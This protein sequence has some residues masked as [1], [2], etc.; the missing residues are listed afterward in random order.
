[1]LKFIALKDTNNGMVYQWRAV[2]PG[3]DE[4]VKDVPK[5]LWK[6]EKDWTEEEI[7]GF[8]GLDEVSDPVEEIEQEAEEKP[9]S[10]LFK[11]STGGTV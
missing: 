1:M 7:K 10:P 3:H 9:S 6:K 11:F 5:P 4:V 2:A 8:L